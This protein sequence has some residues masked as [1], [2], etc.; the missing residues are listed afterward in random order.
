MD[1]GLFQRLVQ[2]MQQHEEILRGEQAPSRGF[3]VD[4]E[5]VKE[6]RVMTGLSQSKFAR[7]LDVDVGTLHNGNRVTPT[8]RSGK[9]NGTSDQARPESGAEGVDQPNRLELELPA[10][11]SSCHRCTSSFIISPYP[12]ER[13][14]RGTSVEAARRSVRSL[15]GTVRVDRD[16]KGY[17]DLS[18]G[19]PTGMVAGA[20]FVCSIAPIELRRR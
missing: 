18:I 5:K 20:G 7:R 9:R 2:S 17:A 16:G 3:F 13:E 14:I 1:K 12:G 19:M 11:A 4:A 6:I 8:D 10:E 15:L